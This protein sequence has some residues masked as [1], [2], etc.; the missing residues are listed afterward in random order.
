M[1]LLRTTAPVQLTGRRLTLRPLEA[2]DFDQWMEVRTRAAGWLRKWEPSIP[3]GHAD[4]SSDRRAFA[5]RCAARDRE[6]QLGTGYGFGMFFEGALAG[7][8]NLSSIQ[9]GPFQSCYVGY[10]VDERHAGKGLTPEAVVVVLR[11]AFEELG[12]HR[13]QVAIIPRNAP[14]R[15]VMA[16]LGI[17][18]EGVAT[19]YLE[20]NG[21]WED[22]VRHAI[23]AEEWAERGSELLDTWVR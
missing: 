21:V 9:R 8:I 12:L 10:W 6:R 5:S 18:E 17:R 19:R 22:H 23:T 14:S 16:K 1:A 15:R 11:F 4:P 2:T 13:V 3:A 20:I 7:E